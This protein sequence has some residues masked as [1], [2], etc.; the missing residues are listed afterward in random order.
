[1]APSLAAAK[2]TACKSDSVELKKITAQGMGLFS[3]KLYPQAARREITGWSC[4]GQLP[5]DLP[6]RGLQQWLFPMFGSYGQTA[7]ALTEDMTTG[8]YKAVHA[9]G[10]LESN[11]FCWQKGVPSVDTGTIE[12]VTYVGGKISE[13]ELSVAKDEIAQL[14]LTMV[15]RNELAG[16]GN[17]DPLN[18]SVPSLQAYTAPASGG[19]FTFLQGTLYTGGTCSTTSGITTVAAPVAAGNIRSASI[20]HT[21]PFDMD[22][23][24]VGNGGFLAEPVQNGLRAGAGQ[25]VVEW[26]SSE[27]RY[28]AYVTD[29]PTPLELTFVGPAIGTGSDFSTLSILVSDMFLEGESPKIGGPEVVVQ[30]IPFTYED[31]GTNNVIQATYW[32][33]DSA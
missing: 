11:S 26:L 20:K 10:V 23:Y 28:N 19:V 3:G 15:F 7:S 1:V 32:T 17:S 12:P 21:V 4:G 13:W 6:A 33:L 25:F 29:T 30:T 22:R 16:S 8:A 9:P 31:D 14:N 5:L 27:A 24:F 2:F 18:V